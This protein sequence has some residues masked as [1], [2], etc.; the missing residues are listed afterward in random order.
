MLTQRA[1]HVTVAATVL[2]AVACGS[3]GAAE[4]ETGPTTTVQ[5]TTAAAEPAPTT[6][7]PEAPGGEDRSAELVG[8]WE[9]TDYALPS[10]SLTNVVGGEPV[11]VEF[12]GDGS[13][14]YHTGC[15][16]GGTAYAT[17]GTY[18]VPESPLDETPEG[19][20]VSFGPDFEQT[21]QGCEGFLGDQDR[22]LPAN[23]GAA[24]RFVIDGDQLTLLDEFLLV[25]ATRSD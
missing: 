12:G 15:N 22:D 6:S 11:F 24:T 3:D 9:V 2:V 13:V 4:G 23:L 25:R 7:A 19:Q 20:T 5:A 10:G 14:S 8:R 1:W 18:A 17:S 21:E 16:A